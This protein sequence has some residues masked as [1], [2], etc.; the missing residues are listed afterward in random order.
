MD[1][2]F[3]L[4]EQK[5]ALVRPSSVN[6]HENRI[7]NGPMALTPLM[8]TVCRLILVCLKKVAFVPTP[9]IINDRW[10]LPEL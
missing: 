8:F 3:V 10:P 6:M 2:Y 4:N 9:Q 7:M 5:P 1:T